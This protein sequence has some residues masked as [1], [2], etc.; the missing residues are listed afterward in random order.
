MG[1][2]AP[3]GRNPEDPPFNLEYYDHPGAMARSVADCILIQNVISGPHRLDIASQLPKLVIPTTLD[4]IKDWRIAY[5]ID[6][7]YHEVDPQVRENT[8]AAL[9]VFK[10]LGATVEEVNLGWTE[11]CTKAAMDH[12][13]YCVM[14][15]YVLQYYQEDK[16]RMTGYARKFAEMVQSVNIMDALEAEITTGEMW[17]SLSAVFE[18]HNLFICPTIANTGVKADFDYSKEEVEINGVKIDPTLGWV[19]TYP[20]NMLSRCPV[21]AVPSGKGANNVP[22]GIQIVG[23]PYDD[24]SVFQAASAYESINGPLCSA[25]SYPQG[26]Y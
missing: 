18:K 22:T 16:D 26:I 9:E 24:I 7:G 5:S 2:K 12:L 11:K 10:E 23:H 20:F 21:L 19:M 14:G 3:Y 1:F 6:L 4:D 17:V 25:S 8:L 13:S 15:S